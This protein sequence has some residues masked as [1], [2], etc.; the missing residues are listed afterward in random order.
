MLASVLFE[1]LIWSL[2]LK[3]CTSEIRGP[4]ESY[5]DANEVVD[6]YCEVLQYVGIGLCGGRVANGASKLS[7]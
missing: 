3:E 1:E 7:T 5:G 6:P 2:F 4:Q